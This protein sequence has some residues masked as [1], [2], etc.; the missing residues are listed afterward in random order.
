M[1][2]FLATAFLAAIFPAAAAAIPAE[3]TFNIVVEAHCVSN[4]TVCGYGTE[5][6]F[7]RATRQSIFDLNNY[8][9]PTGFSFRLKEIN[10]HYGD[11]YSEI[12]GPENTATAPDNLTKLNELRSKASKNPSD[13]Y[14]FV[15]D[16]MSGGCF[17][18]VPGTH[19][20]RTPDPKAPDEYY[21]VFCTGVD[22]NTMAH[23]I[24][25][26]FCLAHPFSHQDP[27]S[28]AAG[29]NHD[30][31]GIADTPEDPGEF[32]YCDVNGTQ[33]KK[34]EVDGVFPVNTNCVADAESCATQI[35]DNRDWCG[36]S[37]VAADAGSFMPFH[38]TSACLRKSG[39]TI[40]SISYSPTMSLTMSYY[41]RPC[42]GPYVYLGQ[43]HEGFSPGEVAVMRSCYFDG[44]ERGQLVNRCAGDTDTDWDGICDKKDPCPANRASVWDADSDNDG[45]PDVC[46][47]CKFVDNLGIDT[48]GDGVD[49]ACDPNDDNDACP[50][51]I[52]DNPTSATMQIGTVQMPGCNT[53][54][55]PVIVSESGNYDN[56]DELDCQD[57][58]DDNDGIPDTEDPCPH[59]ADSEL[60]IIP[61]QGCALETPWEECMGGG[62]QFDLLAELESLRNPDDP[63]QRFGAVIMDERVYLMPRVGHTAGELRGALTGKSFGLVEGGEKLKLSLVNRES[64]DLVAEVGTF[65]IADVSVVGGQ[66]GSVLGVAYKGLAN[67]AVDMT[68]KR[69]ANREGETLIKLE[70]GLTHGLGVPPGDS[71]PDF[72]EDGVP[73]SADN[74]QMVANPAQQDIDGDR[75][76]DACDPDIDNDGFVG[77]NDIQAIGDC[78]G[79]K[80]RP[81]VHF[82]EPGQFIPDGHDPVAAHV[83]AF[84]CRKADLDGD[85]I[86]SQAEGTYAL[87]NEGLTAGPSAFKQTA[88][89]EPPVDP[90]PESVVADSGSDSGMMADVLDD[91]GTADA[92]IMDTLAGDIESQDNGSTG[93]SGGCSATDGLAGSGGVP[94]KSA[95]PLALLLMILVSA[96]GTARL[97]FRK[98]R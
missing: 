59:L 2:A 47:S 31:D 49:N 44:N 63:R 37:Q 80:V 61:G 88:P 5:P 12:T 91:V 82:L 15:L 16:S 52:D 79:V 72:D 55:H 13:V 57:D 11:D 25:H 26:H 23:E 98:S 40:S 60:C 90:A 19:M 65:R 94:G 77:Q 64:G 84:S 58:D 56:D 24:G 27:A 48:D 17:S 4:A 69:A 35:N 67:V 75:F 18:G 7:E 96:F 8:W 1:R 85:G 78:V 45:I 66:T 93:K 73:D 50:D 3:A 38:C 21:G 71:Q 51:D 70:V 6:L 14:W 43:A 30:G 34:A 89:V 68:G 81:D 41:F 28:P 36:Y 33:D 74:C 62:C 32:E 54:T 95:L 86:V 42:G 83:G 92:N 53:T 22:G 10:Y 29:V 46:D 20:G 39:G 87:N 9:R 76:G 97:T